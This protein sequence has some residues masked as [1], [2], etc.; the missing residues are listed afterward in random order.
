MTQLMKDRTCYRCKQAV[1]R[2]TDRAG[3]VCS[4]CHPVPAG[5]VEDA[6]PSGAEVVVS[7]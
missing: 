2:Y 6:S 5:D 1:Y 7:R 4:V 3:W